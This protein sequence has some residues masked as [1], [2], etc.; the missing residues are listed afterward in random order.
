MKSSHLDLGSRNV[1]R[2]RHSQLG[3]QLILVSDSA[4]DHMYHQIAPSIN[5]NKNLRTI[6]L[7]I[8]NIDLQQIYSGLLWIY[9]SVL[10]VYSVLS[11]LQDRRGC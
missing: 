4:V 10:V 2:H 8:D 7:R 3:C 9:Y 1:V 11:Q 6:W 5:K